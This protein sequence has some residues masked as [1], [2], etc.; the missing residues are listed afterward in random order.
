MAKQEGRRA[1]REGSIYQSADGR[2]R[3]YVTTGYDASGRPKRSYISGATRAE[4]NRKLRAAQRLADARL[5]VPSPRLTVAAY[6]ASWLETFARPRLKE[7]AYDQYE[8]VVRNHIVPEL[9]ATKLSRLSALEVQALYA[10]KLASGLAPRTVL[11][12]HRVLHSSLSQAERWELVA[13]NVAELVDAP[14][15]PRTE[16]R[17]MNIEQARAFLDAV[18]GDRLEAL[19]VVALAGGLRRGEVLAL[20]WDD[21]DFALGT[22]AVR[23]SLIKIRGGWAFAEPKSASS[24]RVVRL[25]DFVAAALREHRAQQR[26]ARVKARYWEDP[27]LVFS[28]AIGTVID[29]R[30]LLRQF[31]LQVAAAGLDPKLFTFHGLRHSAATLMLALGVQPKVVSETLG[32]SRVGITLDTYSHVLPHLQE[33]AASR[34]DALL[35]RPAP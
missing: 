13:R 9:G 29:G 24:R 2:H 11:Y 21:I 28:S 32:H 25:P 20:R 18:R 8:R 30:Q 12:I 5:P 16:V 22:L 10:K 23:R 35:A 27:S 1:N 19:Y 3:G 4:V 33:E 6:M 7:S 26:E 31:K 15:A 17:A 34:M 14:R